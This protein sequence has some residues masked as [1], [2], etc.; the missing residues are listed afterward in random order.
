V[1]GIIVG[2][3]VAAVYYGLSD[4]AETEGLAAEQH[5]EKGIAYLESQDYELASAEFELALQL[6]PDHPDAQEGLSQAEQSLVVQ[7]TATPMLQ[8]EVKEAY[9][10]EL[11][12]AYE[13]GDWQATF[14]QADRLLALD[15][16]YQRAQID[17]ILF[18]SFYQSGLELVG[19]DRVKEAVRLYDRAL[20]LQPDNAQVQMAKRS[21]NLYLTAMGYWGADWSKAI[22]NLST[23]YGLDPS[24]RDVRDRLH[25]AHVQYAEQ[26]GEEDSWCASVDEYTAALAIRADTVITVARE[27]AQQACQSSSGDSG[28]D[29][30][31]PEQP[32]EATQPPVAPA[33]GVA[34]GAYYGV[35][36]EMEGVG[37]TKI[38]VRGTVENSQ[39]APL[40]SAQIKIQAWD[41]SAVAVTDSMGQYAFDGLTNPVTYTL[42]VL[43]VECVPFDV[44][45]ESGE[46]AWVDFYQAE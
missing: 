35:L 16:T 17:Q 3:G 30:A 46:I 41:W 10:D 18:D 9:F 23:L 2:L 1:I 33:P 28:S 34:S 40:P 25:S 21:A 29:I 42:T 6:D 31:Q 13:R 22:E 43:G 26:L 19:A 20:D 12:L 5:Y 7:P 38:F 4:R 45:G 32:N 15:P 37:D 27:Q 8:K 24:F 36:R 11:V 39:G 44:A 14:D